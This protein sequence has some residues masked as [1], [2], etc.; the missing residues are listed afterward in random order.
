MKNELSRPL[1][2]HR[3][4]EYREVNKFVNSI[5][6]KYFKWQNSDLIKKHLKVVLLDLYLAWNEHPDM[7]I[8][9]HM[10]R[11]AYKA[12][13]RYNALNISH[14]IIDVVKRLH[15]IGFINLTTGFYDP[16]GRLSRVTRIW[17]TNKL[18]SKFKSA[19]FTNHHIIHFTDQEVIILRDENKKDVEYNDDAEIIQMRNVL[20]EYNNLLKQTF[21]D[22]PE[23]DKP[24]IETNDKYIPISSNERLVRR[25]FNNAS[26]KDGGRFYGGWWQR[27]PS[28]FRSKIYLNNEGTIEDDYRSLHPNLLYANKGLDYAK[29]KRGDAYDIHVSNINDKDDKRKLVKRLM[30]IAINAKDE[31]TTFRAVKSELQEEIPY[32]SFKF[33]NLK[34]ILNNLKEKH[35][36]IADDFCTGKGL[37]LMNLDGKIAEYII[38]KFTQNNIPVLCIHD[39]FVVPRSKDDFLRLTM[40][41]AIVNITNQGLPNI[42]RKG[43]GLHE[44]NSVKHLD[45]DLYL[46]R[47]I[48]LS[49]TAPNRSE[50]YLYRKQLFEEYSGKVI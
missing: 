21:I 35:H 25:I 36:E 37:Q 28:F 41:E 44:I 7:K 2:V 45:R 29:L 24:I 11:N 14:K 40:N 23:L 39:S 50:G 32:F 22:I 47:M 6:E 34:L 20:N 5:F 13:S 31:A 48:H 17:S 38:D 10:N 8:G 42:D 43:L 1:D 27:V 30:L 4:S 12:K 19:K 33:D 18:I 9:V 46:D 49:E 16:T 26:W 3:W 15:E